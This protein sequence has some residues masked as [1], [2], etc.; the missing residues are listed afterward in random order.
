M[1]DMPEIAPVVRTPS[2]VARLS[3]TL[4]TVAVALALPLLVTGLAHAPWLAMVHLDGNDRAIIW[5][6]GDERA[7]HEAIDTVAADPVFPGGGSAI[8][9]RAGGLGV[10]PAGCPANAARLHF[11]I[12]RIDEAQPARAALEQ[13][14]ATSG[15]VVC[16]SN[17]FEINRAEDADSWASLPLLAGIGLAL[18]LVLALRLAPA[19]RRRMLRAGVGTSRPA[20]H[21]V[22][23]VVGAAA[24]TLALPIRQED[25]LV[26]VHSAGFAMVLALWLQP[27]IHEIAFR[28]WLATGLASI[29]GRPWA[30]AASAAASVLATMPVSATSLL[31]AAL[32][33]GTCAFAWWRGATVAN[34]IALHLAIAAVARAMIPA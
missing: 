22:A 6:A 28:G 15:A 5:I 1:A 17:I 33:G 9:N 34:C 12:R 32:V 20:G 14:A 29:A 30:A 19:T 7:L 4:R 13:I 16:A 18:A 8:P 23:L 2:S 11:D 21:T 27:A 24:L 26:A 10:A 3:H 31:Q 25:G